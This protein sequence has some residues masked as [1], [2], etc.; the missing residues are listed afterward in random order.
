MTTTLARMV[1][2]VGLDKAVPVHPTLAGA[3]GHTAEP[4]E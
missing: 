4:E 1:T 2:L 3:L